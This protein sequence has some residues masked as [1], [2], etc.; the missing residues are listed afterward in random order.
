MITN[1]ANLKEGK[2]YFEDCR[3]NDFLPFS[4]R[5]CELLFCEE[6]R[7]TENHNCKASNS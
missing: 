3:K 4:C 1:I 6:H 7:F 5:Y 2:C